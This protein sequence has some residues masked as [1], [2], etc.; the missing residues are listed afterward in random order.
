MFRFQ[1]QAYIHKKVAEKAKDARKIKKHKLATALVSKLV[2]R[3]QA[4]KNVDQ[5]SQ[6]INT[7]TNHTASMQDDAEEGEEADDWF[8]DDQETNLSCDPGAGLL[9]LLAR[10]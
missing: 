10:Q 3:T 2:S 9:E 7:V 1:A 8:D 6:V 4:D 5:S